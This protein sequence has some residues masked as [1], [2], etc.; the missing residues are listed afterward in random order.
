[1]SGG[2]RLVDGLGLAAA[3]TGVVVEGGPRRLRFSDPLS[4]RLLGDRALLDGSR[5][6]AALARA[7][8]LDPDDVVAAIAALAARGVLTTGPR[9]AN[10]LAVHLGRL[11]P[12]GTG[13]RAVRRLTDAT[14]HVAGT[15][16]AADTVED[17]LRRSGIGAVHR[18]DAERNGSGPPDLVIAVDVPA[19]VGPDCLPVTSGRTGSTVGPLV[20]PAGDRCPVCC[21][22][23]GT[24][25]AAGPSPQGPGLTAAALFAA[26]LA[27]GVAVAFLGGHLVCTAHGRRLELD[28]A[29]GRVTEVPVGNRPDCPHCGADPLPEEDG[30]LLALDYEQSAETVRTG[31]ERVRPSGVTAPP[32]KSYLD[33]PRLR[34]RGADQGLSGLRALLAALVPVGRRSGRAIPS[35]G[36]VGSVATFV[37]PTGR[38]GPLRAGA[39]LDL[40]SRELV[41]LRPAG[42]GGTGPARSA[43][44]ALVGDLTATTGR[45]GAG[46]RRILLHDAGYLLGRL[47]DSA[48]EL[49]LR[50]SLRTDWTAAG[51]VEE[52]QLTSW[53]APVAV[54]D[55]KIPSGGVPGEPSAP[56]PVTYEFEPG[57]V[58]AGEVDAVLADALRRLGADG[59]AALTNGLRAVAY[60]QD[61]PTRELVLPGGD[62]GPATTGDRLTAYLSDRGLRLPAVVLVASDL[63]PLLA[64]HGADGYQ[65]AVLR[66]AA[67]TYLVAAAA[68]RRGQPTGLLARLPSTALMERVS[69][70]DGGPRLLAGVALG[71]RP[72][73]GRRATGTAVLW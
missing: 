23:A 26:G 58:P 9:P 64:E 19:P 53:D 50:W 2:V 73:R 40:R 13:D 44:L 61:G 28:P 35:V 20:G 10:E 29:A 66:S 33:L 51:V 48:T 27:V 7:T 52:L 21:A 49:G 65:S 43:S 59:A 1:M 32:G 70:V 47:I 67:V 62:P 36:D 37:L 39:F 5:D 38:P 34:L 16:P 14:V 8:G 11:Y 45:F 4:T 25:D 69:A 46:G 18:V 3:G 17:L 71:D 56:L 42:P 31:P 55:L 57:G 24:A 68:A 41:L 15:G 12:D 54:L 6:A 60:D 30:A 72:A 22:S 63:R